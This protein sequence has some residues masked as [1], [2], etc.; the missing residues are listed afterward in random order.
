MAVHPERTVRSEPAVARVETPEASGRFAICC[1]QASNAFSESRGGLGLP[2]VMLKLG[3]D[4]S[5]A[6]AAAIEPT[7]PAKVAS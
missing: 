3:N 4:L 2:A 7:D 6:A 5:L 1:E